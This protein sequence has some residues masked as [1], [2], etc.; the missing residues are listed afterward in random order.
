MNILGID[1]SMFVLIAISFRAASSHNV[2]QTDHMGIV[3][4]LGGADEGG[5]TAPSDALDCWHGSLVV[6][7]PQ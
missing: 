3:C 6:D 1:D 7:G 5:A 2:S 4:S